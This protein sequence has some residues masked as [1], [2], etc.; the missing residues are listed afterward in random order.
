MMMEWLQILDF[1]ENKL[2][3]VRSF[4]MF[5]MP[6]KGRLINNHAVLV[7]IDKVCHYLENRSEI[8]SVLSPSVLYQT[9]SQ[10]YHGGSAE[11]FKLPESQKAINTLDDNFVGYLQ[12]NKFKILWDQDKLFGR[13]TAKMTDIGSDNVKIMNSEIAE[14]IETN[15]DTTLV[16]FMPTGTALMVDKNHE[17]IRSSLFYS[18]GLAFVVVGLLMAVLF[19]SP[20]MV[21]ISLIPNLLPLLI[22]AGFMAK[23]SN[24]PIQHP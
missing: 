11:H 8:G 23:Q 13:V 5:I 24:H 16:S 14:W 18:L 7:E 17:Y 4:E 9:F 21:L 10:A 19:K 22:T 2:A 15:V 20:L 6:H 12:Q 3:G 1:F